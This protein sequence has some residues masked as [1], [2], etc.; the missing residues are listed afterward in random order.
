MWLYARATIHTV[1]RKYEIVATPTLTG[2]YRVSLTPIYNTDTP[3]ARINDHQGP[4]VEVIDDRFEALPA[5]HASMGL[6]TVVAVDA[7]LCD[8]LLTRRKEGRSERE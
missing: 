1:G 7:R 2:E 6:R 8:G 3:T 5:G 4:C